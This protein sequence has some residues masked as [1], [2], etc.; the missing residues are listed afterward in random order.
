MKWT[1]LA[2]AIVCEVIGTSALKASDGFTRLVP[3]LVVVAGYVSAFYLLSLSV[4]TIPVGVVYAIWSGVGVVLITL[5]AMILYHQK[6]DIPAVIGVSLITLGVIII[7]VFSK[8]V[9]E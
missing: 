1:L 8:T 3:S 5:A 9:G 7:N 4:R 2:I 6:L